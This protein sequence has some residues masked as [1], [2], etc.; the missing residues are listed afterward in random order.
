M[1]RGAPGLM[2]N[3]D[4]ARH[5]CETK[6]IE[7][8]RH[9]AVTTDDRQAAQGRR[10]ANKATALALAMIVAFL[11][12]PTV[13]QAQ[14]ND[15]QE[16]TVTFLG[17]PA[18]G[19]VRA[20]GVVS[21]DGTVEVDHYQ[22][23]QATGRFHVRAR[24]VFPEGTLFITAKGADDFSHLDPETCVVSYHGRA[25]F[26]VTGGTGEF[27]GAMGR[28]TDV[29]RGRYLLQRNPDGSCSEPGQLYERV[30]VT[31]RLRLGSSVADA[32]L[33]MHP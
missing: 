30:W 13:A 27:E 9:T 16:F 8:N 3:L 18:S 32:G 12:V 4:D 23:D 7:M 14:T 31:A 11:A 6:E 29:Y 1:F 19:T 24:Y 25:R 17:D 15:R 33:M 10:R 5:L 22:F 20:E 2:I 21:G 28:G 26:W